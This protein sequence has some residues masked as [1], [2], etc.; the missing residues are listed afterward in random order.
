MKNKI[1]LLFAVIILFSSFTEKEVSFVKEFR[2]STPANLLISTSGG[3]I[4]TSGYDKDVIEVSFIVKRRNQVMD[5]TLEKLQEL[6]EIEITQENNNVQISVKKTFEKGISVGFDV[7]TPYKTSCNL[8]TSGGH[9]DVTDVTGNQEFKTSGGHLS[10]SN[11]TGNINANT[12]GGHI[13]I[14]NSKADISAETSGGHISMENIEGSINT[15]TSG[16]S[17]KITNAKF[18]V[19]AETSGGSID[20]DEVQGAIEL[21]TSGGHISLKNISGSVQAVTSG[22]GITA[23]IL[24]LKDKLILKTS[25]GSISANIPPDLGLDLNLKGSKV[26]ISL[27]NFSGNSQKNA[28][29]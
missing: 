28:W 13:T 3:S 10:F 29:P 9:I 24:N 20:L 6:A 21:K 27:K 8:H 23:D 22:G 2:V 16:G 4:S 19:I 26:N 14:N 5:V 18:D 25:G 11:I 15:H 1:F 7:K 17:I 12:S